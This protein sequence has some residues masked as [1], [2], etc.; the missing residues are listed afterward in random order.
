MEASLGVPTATSVR[1]IPAK[2]LEVNRQIL[3]NQLARTGAGK[4]SFTHLI[5]YAV[6]RALADFPALNSAYGTEDGKPVVVRHQ[7]VNLGLAV[8]VQKRDGTHSLLV[9]NVKE[10]GTLDFAGFSRAYEDLIVK[11]RG[12]K[13]SPDDFAGTTASITNPGM[14][15]TVHSVPR[16]MPGQGF[17]VGVGS[18]GYPAEFAGADP[19]TLAEIGISKVTTLT[20]TYDHRIITGA[21]SGEFLRRIH[22]LLLGEDEF[23]DQVFASLAVPYEPARW[24]ADRSGFTDPATQNEKVVQVHAL[25]NMYRVRGHLIANLD[26]LGRRAPDTHPELDIT[27]HELSIWDLDREFPIGNLGAGRLPRKVMP[28]RDILGV[29]RDAYARTVGVEYMHIQEHDQ[30]EWLQEQIE[31]PYPLVTAAEKHRILER[32]NAAE[33]FERFLHTKYLGQ[34]RFSLEGAETLVPM[35]DALC[36]LA[37]DTGMSDVVL[38]MAHRGRLNVLANV[39]GKSYSQIFR[40]FEGELDPSTTQG[41]GDVKYHLGAVGKHQ[42]PSGVEVKLTLAANPSHL[43][44]VGPVVEGVGARGRRRQRRRGPS[45]GAPRAAARRRRVRGTGSGGGD[46]QPLRGPRLRGGWH[47][48]RGGQ[49]PARLHHRSRARSLERLSHRRRQDGP[50]ADLPRQRRRPRS[51]GAR[52]EA[53]VRVPQPLQEGRRRRPL[54]LPAVRTQRGRR[55]GLHPAAHVRAH[56][57]APP[58]ARALHPAVGAAGRHHA[59]RRAGGRVRLQGTTRPRVR[60]DPRRSRRERRGDADL[61]DGCLDDEDEE[62]PP[63]DDPVA[64]A[65]PVATLERVVEGLDARPEGFEVN[66][67]LERQLAARGA[68]IGKDEIDWAM[69]EAL[70]FGSLVLEGTPVRLAGQDTRRGTF[71]QRH[72][73][74]VDQSTEREHVPLAHLADDQAPFMLY[75]TVLSEY[76]ALGFEYGYSISSDA[77]VCWE[78]QFGDFA[79]VA[80]AVIDQFIATAADKWGQRSSLA[81]LLPHGLEGQGPE[82]SSAR[83]ERYLTL[84]AEGNLRVVYPTTAAQYF[85]VLRRQAVSAR[86][87]PL[88]CFTP[89][90]Y[91]RMP[92]TR[93]PLAAFTERSF[94]PVLDDR[95]APDTVNRVI[96]CTGMIAHELMDERDARGAPA[97]IVRIEELYPWPEAL[98]FSV[99]D[100]YPD[101]KQVWWV[102][103]EPAN[104]GAWNYIHIRLHRVLRDRAKLKHVSRAPSASP[105][106]GSSKIHDAE[107]R[108]LLAAAFAKL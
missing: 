10:A 48:P 68:M 86:H 35:L 81:M 1:V 98:L 12:N 92:H 65:V 53:R 72:G 59:R 21:E 89:K 61:T 11:V 43:E 24:L 100:R 78:A 60:G 69:A 46:V 67:K 45:L 17:I 51:R 74:L 39:I 28:F 27:H 33:A 83:I 102:Q 82:H 19:A 29:L 97:A 4:V 2:L 22:E 101:A 3:N 37:A 44:A 30:K 7:H 71:S 105:A 79:N 8:D 103:P 62:L 20:N 18:I 75:D 15:G 99:L 9:P 91:L 54:L 88:V 56:R 31:V 64:T 36:T 57:R 13:I 63:V 93:S 85:H 90:R 16:L 5:A 108:A 107:Q 52:D 6:L 38:G 70:A 34:K 95:N 66:P 84:S 42:S 32:L 104:M 73:V 23:Y 94:S 77:L 87:V 41:S 25:I 14:I 49:Q 50:G 55:A 80:Q 96:L 106:S 26:P 76:A 47:R 58:G 40:E